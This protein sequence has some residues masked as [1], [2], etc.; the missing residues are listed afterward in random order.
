MLSDKE[1]NSWYAGEKVP[2]L[3]FT[4]DSP[5]RVISG[6]HTGDLVALICIEETGKNIVYLAENSK[7]ESYTIN[8]SSVEPIT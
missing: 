2:N 3:K 5:V 4:I 6:E 7:G 8:E 1:L